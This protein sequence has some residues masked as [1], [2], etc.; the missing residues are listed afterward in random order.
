AERRL[1]PGEA[2]GLRVRHGRGARGDADAR[3]RRH[4]PVLGERP[5][6]PEA[7]LIHGLGESVRSCATAVSAVSGVALRLAAAALTADTAR[8]PLAGWPHSPR[9][10]ARGP[11]AP[12]GASR[13]AGCSS[14]RPRRTRTAPPAGSPRWQAR[15]SD[16]PSASATP[17]P[18]ASATGT[19]APAPPPSR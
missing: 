10:P 9:T 15:R 8:P 3:H 19:V 5:A 18:A 4:P 16:S 11:H 2:L 17:P 14:R 1:R 12:P 13:R 7:V 6:V